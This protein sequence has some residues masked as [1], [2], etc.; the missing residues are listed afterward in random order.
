MPSGFPVRSIAHLPDRRDTAKQMCEQLSYEQSTTSKSRLIKEVYLYL[1]VAHCTEI[2]IG[3]L[4]KSRPL[5]VVSTY[6]MS[7]AIQIDHLSAVKK[8][9]SS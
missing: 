5:M 2:K 3:V 9:L 7:Q 4:R 1:K 6:L 8:I